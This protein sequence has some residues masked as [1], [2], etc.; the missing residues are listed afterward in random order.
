M[1]CRF[2]GRFPKQV[3][4]ALEKRTDASWRS[5]T[6]P[7]TCQKSAQAHEPDA[8]CP[9]RG[10]ARKGPRKVERTATTAFS[11]LTRNACD[12][13]Q[14]LNAISNSL[15]ANQNRIRPQCP[16]NR[17]RPL[18]GPYS[19]S[20][21]MHRHPPNSR[22]P[23]ATESVAWT[24]TPCFWSRYPISEQTSICGNRFQRGALAAPSSPPLSAARQ[25]RSGRTDRQISGT[26]PPWLGKAASMPHASSD[27]AQTERRLSTWAKV[28]EG[29]S[30][31]TSR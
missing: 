4:T 27:I 31:M 9:A 10:C 1:R 8:V 17:R 12:S 23:E 14:R 20:I 2:M 22:K 30:P 29:D 26:S 16:A 24:L 25:R 6:D 7:T 3:K 15:D 13:D 18:P 28:W 5:C 19:S 11:R 21:Q